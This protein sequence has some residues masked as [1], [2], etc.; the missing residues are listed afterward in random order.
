MLGRLDIQ[1]LGQVFG[2]QDVQ[3]LLGFENKFGR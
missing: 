1:V 3:N 2:P